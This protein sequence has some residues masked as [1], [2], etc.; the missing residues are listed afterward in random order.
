MKHDHSWLKSYNDELKDKHVL[1]LG[2]GSGID[3]AVISKLTEHIIASDLVPKA[4]YSKIVDK[5]D[6]S[7]PLPFKG[8]SF[9]TVVASLCLH[10]FSLDTTK[11][12]ISEI[13]RVLKPQG[14]LVCRVNSHKDTN[15]G[16]VGYP[17]IEPG[18]YNVNGAQKRFFQEQQIQELWEQEY[19][20]GV[21]FHK[22][23]DRYQKTKYVYEFKAIKA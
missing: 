1:E 6:H 18:L 14:T 4:N 19:S 12:I 10:Y 5:I 2:C 22:G 23:I 15:Y 16:A 21:I 9:H 17:E 7:E 11:E 3:T 20:V 13:S 8:E